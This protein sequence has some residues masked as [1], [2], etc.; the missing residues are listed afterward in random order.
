MKSANSIKVLTL[1]QAMSG[2]LSDEELHQKETTDQWPRISLYEKTLHSDMLNERFIDCVPVVRKK[3]YKRVPMF[4]AQVLEAYIIRNRYDVI[5]SWAEN[6]GLPFAALM[7]LTGVQKPH[8]GIFS[9]ISKPKKAVILKHVQSHF[10]RIVLMSSAQRDFALHSLNI[11]E[12]KIAFLRWPVDLQFWRPMENVSLDM[13][14]SVGREMRDYGTLLSVVKEMGI[15]C[16]IAAGGLTMGEKKDAWVRQLDGIGDIPHFITIGKKSYPE[17]RELYARSKF[18]VIPILPTDTD[19]GTTSILEAMSMGK[20]VICSK[21]N[22]QRDVL[23]DGKN[24]IFVPPQNPRALREAIEFLWANPSIASEMGKEARRF[25]EMNHS[26]DNFVLK[27]HE[28]V[29]DVV[30][31]CRDRM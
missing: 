29:D 20:A 10:D 30:M 13:I 7:K 14:C 18:V 19:N 5:V 17:L 9:W 15:K 27:I 2:R 28:I 4:S 31:R 11:P 1:T 6:L 3:I 16:H 21:T 8:I 26:L 24:G 23:Q 25:V 12:R 22:G